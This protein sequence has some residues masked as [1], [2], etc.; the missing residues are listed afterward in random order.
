MRYFIFLC[1]FILYTNNS[2]AQTD[3]ELDGE[4]D[5][6]TKIDDLSVEKE[7]ENTKEDE[8]DFDSQIFKR[9]IYGRHN[10]AKKAINIENKI[11]STILH[12]RKDFKDRIRNS[13]GKY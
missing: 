8:E 13:L 4:L 6:D 11:S 3:S 9:N 12:P 2:I 10:K 1:L 7:G 5:T